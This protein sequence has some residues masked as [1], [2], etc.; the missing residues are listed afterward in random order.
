MSLFGNTQNTN[1]QQGSSLFGNTASNNQQQGSS[2]FGGQQQPQQQGTTSLFGAQPAQQQNTINH[3]PG[4][5]IPNSAPGQ[6]STFPTATGPIQSNNTSNQSTAH[7]PLASTAQHDLAA[8]RLA[9]SGIHAQRNEKKTFDQV[10]TLVRKWDP[11][12]QDTVLQ[13]YLYNAVS[14]TYAP[15]YYRNVDE[16]EKEWEEALRN[17]PAPVKGDG[18][19]VS[20]VPVLVR[21]FRALG[22]R[23][24]FQARTVNEMR[25]RLHE[26]NNRYA[27]HESPGMASFAWHR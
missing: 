12:S 22:E 9:A 4:T 3:Q 14:S 11:Q 2:L 15:F 10:Q 21:G 25:A 24:E 6:F 27:Y 8:S 7:N 1:A 23:V 18:E 19:D 13:S 5:T 26:M 16:G 20:F 17:K